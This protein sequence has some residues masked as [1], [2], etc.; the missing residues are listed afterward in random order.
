MQQ[1]I[2]TMNSMRV[3]N[4]NHIFINRLK[5]PHLK[6]L[7]RI[8]YSFSFSSGFFFFCF[9]IF[10]FGNSYSP[11][12][13]LNDYRFCVFII[14]RLD[15]WDSFGRFSRS[16]NKLW[17]LS[18]NPTSEETY[19][20]F[21]FLKNCFSLRSLLS[22]SDVFP[23]LSNWM[24]LLVFSFPFLNSWGVYNF[25]KLTG[26]FTIVSSFSSSFI[27]EQSR[28]YLYLFSLRNTL[29]TLLASRDLVYLWVSLL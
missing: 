24:A 4:S 25:L 10:N 29:A 3:L 6:N 21:A 27:S 12:Y 9:C 28:P 26:F 23:S 8:V 22:P 15:K 17:L 2:T 1:K 11:L 14:R 13:V 16:G 19:F 5:L 20:T 18:V 7:H